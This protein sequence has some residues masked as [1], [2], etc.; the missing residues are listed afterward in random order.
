M[1]SNTPQVRIIEQLGSLV[2][3][4]LRFRNASSADR[5]ETD[6]SL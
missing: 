6:A 2:I 4:P 5:C 3:L 1:Q